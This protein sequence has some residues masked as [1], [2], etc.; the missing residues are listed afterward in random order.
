MSVEGSLI[1]ANERQRSA[2][3]SAELALSSALD[4]S[5]PLEIV[6]EDIRRACFFLESLI[7]RVGVEDVL[8]R[9]FAK[10]CVG[11]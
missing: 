10:F 8:D 7:G 11:K 5:A 6:A 3:R 9:I 1:I 2:L 4:E